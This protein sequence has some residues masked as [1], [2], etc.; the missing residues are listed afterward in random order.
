MQG[1]RRPLYAQRLNR[2][3]AE[4][5]SHD[6][7]CSSSNVIVMDLEQNHDLSSISSNQAIIIKVIKICV[8]IF[9]GPYRGGCYIFKMD[10]PESYPFKVVDVFAE[11]PIWHP[12][13]DLVSG[14]V[15]LP[16]EWSPVITLNSLALAVQVLFIYL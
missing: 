10:I 4:L 3:I 13:I 1:D 11:Q 8:K 2:D 12:N 7:S 14:R 6:F 9:E 5:F 16:I 15:V